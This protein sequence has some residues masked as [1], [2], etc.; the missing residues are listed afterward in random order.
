[1]VGRNEARSVPDAFLNDRDQFGGLGLVFT[2]VTEREYLPYEFLGPLD[3]TTDPIKIM[4]YFAVILD[5][6]TTACKSLD[7]HEDIFEIVRYAGR[8]R[9]DGLHLLGLEQLI[10]EPLVVG[11]VLV[12]AVASGNTPRGIPE[13]SRSRE[14]VAHLTVTAND[15]VLKIDKEFGV[16]TRVAFFCQLSNHRPVVRVY[17]PLEVLFGSHP[18]AALLLGG[19]AVKSVKRSALTRPLLHKNRTQNPSKGKNVA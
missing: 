8:E 17:E 6:L 18:V 3:G 7:G 19:G 9:A 5:M 2:P 14:D 12:C 4:L 1:M 10:L 15:T 11:D 13:S 16:F